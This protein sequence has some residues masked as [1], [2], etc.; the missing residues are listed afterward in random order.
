MARLKVGLKGLLDV[1]LRRASRP[2]GILA[3]LGLAGT[4]SSSPVPSRPHTQPPLTPAR[5]TVQGSTWPAGYSRRRRITITTGPNSP[6]GGYNGYTVRVTGFDTATEVA[7]GDIRADGNDLRVFYWNGAGWLEVPRLVTGFN[8]ADTHVIFKVQTDIAASAADTDHYIFYGNPSAGAPEAL[9]NTNV[10]L[11]YDDFSTDPFAAGSSRYTRAKAVDIHGQN[12]AVPTY[13]AANL[14]VRFDTGDNI[15]SDMYV[16]NAGFS[17]TEQD[18]LVAVD[19]FADLNYPTNA[20]DAI[21]VR[22][23]AINTTSTHIYLHYSHGS[24]P[25][26]PAVTWDSWTNGERNSLGGTGPLT[27]WPFNVASTWAFAVF[28]TT[29]KFWEDGDLDPEPWFDAEPPLLT[30]STTPPQ[31]GYAGVA[32]AQSRGWWDN[33]VVRRYTE[34]EPTTGIA[35]EEVI[36]ATVAMSKS[37]NPSGAAAPGTDLTYTISLTSQG[38]ADAVNTVIVDSLAAEVEF[39]LGSIVTSLPAG[40]T[41]VVEYSNDGGLSWTYTPASGGCGAPAGYD[42]CVTHIRWTFQN[43]FPATPP[44]NTGSLQFV[45]RI[46]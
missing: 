17:N 4:L 10:Y 20:T 24:Y 15:T 39:K 45:A 1:P 44:N 8:T 5:V 6:A 3:V 21:V 33:F 42:G 18:I 37:V 25:E 46:R 35:V 9:S 36:T 19:H 2:A 31:P 29:A 14:R 16:D 38:N 12:Y 34:P 43:D 40:V 22:T 30:G 27:Y 13:D 7:Q 41:A 28:G 26:S 11:W 32:P 23:S